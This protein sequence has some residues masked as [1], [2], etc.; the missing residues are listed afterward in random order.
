MQIKKKLIVFLLTMVM[1]VSAT[2]SGYAASSVNLV[3]TERSNSKAEDR[4]YNITYSGTYVGSI[5]ACSSYHTALLLF[6]TTGII[7]YYTEKTEM[8]IRYYN[9]DESGIILVD[10]FNDTGTANGT[11]SECYKSLNVDE[12]MRSLSGTVSLDGFWSYAVNAVDN[13]THY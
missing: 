6:Q 9:K 3:V 10:S 1:A 5:D 12:Y 8:T 4:K 13:T 11:K 2:V 7:Q